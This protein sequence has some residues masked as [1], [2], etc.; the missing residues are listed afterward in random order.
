MIYRSYSLYTSHISISSSLP[1]TLRQAPWRCRTPAPLPSAAAWRPAPWAPHCV[2]WRWA[3]AGVRRSAPWS[4]G[5][6]DYI[7]YYYMVLWYILWY[8]IVYINNNYGILW[9]ILILWDYIKYIYYGIW[10]Y[11]YICDIMV[12]YGIIDGV[13][14]ISTMVL[15]YGIN[16]CY[17]VYYNGIIMIST[18]VL[19]GISTMVLLWYL[20]Y[21]LYIYISTMVL[22]YIMIMVYYSR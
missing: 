6:R 17:M 14:M 20:L 1:R 15:L 2:A 19:Y 7:N 13:I 10:W 16:Y 22:W 3:A 21:L 9:Y 12:D 18:M 4:N 5:A 8:Y 11:I